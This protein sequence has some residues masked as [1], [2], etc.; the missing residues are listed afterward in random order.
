MKSRTSRGRVQG[1]ARETRTTGSTTPRAEE[2]DT[3]VRVHKLRGGM[4]LRIGGQYASL[5]RPGKIT[6]GSVWD[7][8]AIP[9]LLSPHRDAPR[10][11]LLGV[12]GGSVLPLIRALAPAGRVVGV[13]LDPQ[14]VRAA[15]AHFGLDAHGVEIIEADAERVLRRDRRKFDV[16][17]DDLYFH[18]GERLRKPAFLPEPGL[19]LAAA[20]LARGGILVTNVVH[21]AAHAKRVL[22][23]RFGGGL[24]L[25]L[26]DCNNRILFAG[27]TLP[28]A[29][30][31]RDRLSSE[32]HFAPLVPKLVIR[33]FGGPKPRA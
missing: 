31:L 4:V 30:E 15:R 12:G 2:S 33:R 5:A 17:I 14:V 13:E 1:D 19:D 22:T 18:D 28:G 24:E 21:E 26:D 25:R 6:T 23:S 9:L 27:D 8:L 7:L 29:R 3:R 11:L 16:V 32:P 20:R 10:V